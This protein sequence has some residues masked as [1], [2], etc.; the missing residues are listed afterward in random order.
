MVPELCTFPC[1]A[2]NWFPIAEAINLR[3]NLSVGCSGEVR[4]IDFVV[5]EFHLSTLG[6]ASFLKGEY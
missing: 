5:Y 1:S 2:M 4:R 3:I 6:H